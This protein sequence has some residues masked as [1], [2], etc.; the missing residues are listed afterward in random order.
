[1]GTLLK[2]WSYLLFSDISNSVINFIVFTILARKL[3]PEGYGTFNIVLAEVALFTVV[4]SNVGANHVVTREVTLYPEK[5]T[6]IFVNTSVLRLIGIFLAIILLFIYYYISDGFSSQNIFFLLCLLMALNV[7]WDLSESV[8]FGHFTTKY[9][10][11]FNILFS[12][13]WLLSV[14][15]LPIGADDLLIVL[16]AYTL[17]FF[18]K[19]FGYFAIVSIKYIKYRNFDFHSSFN[20]DICKSLLLMSLPYF[21]M[22]LFG[23][24][25]EQIPML[26]LDNKSGVDQVGYYSVGF[27][28]IMPITIAVN[29][30]LRA[31]FPFITKLYY[32]NKSDFSKKILNAFI[33]IFVGGTFISTLLILFSEYW[34]PFLLGASYVDAIIP[35]NFLAWFGVGMC[36]DLM[37]ATLLSSTY[38]QNILMVI[39]IVDFG[40]S[41]IFLLLGVRY[42]AIGLALAK[43]VSLM[44]CLAYH[45]V[46]I[47]KIFNVN[48]MNRS[49]LF[50][51]LLYLGSILITS[52]T[53][54]VF[55]K[56]LIVLLFWLLL[57]RC[58]DNPIRTC[59]MLINLKLNK[60]ES[61]SN[62]CDIQ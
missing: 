39:T 20:N 53:A 42:G 13:G 58:S 2:N 35:F 54:S 26:I 19:S 9:T 45:F 40:I 31:V 21:V 4:A 55:I 49:F 8:A 23:A 38:K 59:V 22:R 46:I 28:L 56:S 1:M 44:I 34:I 3:T 47:H 30:G 33:F 25:S 61:S 60:N 62:N 50:S 51:L 57:Y 18:I 43:L 6:S 36:C 24:F 29:T 15:L 48:L 11:I 12:L 16:I 7:V 5:T 17:F 14:L 41:V 52:I 37:L 32:E 27:R 10:T